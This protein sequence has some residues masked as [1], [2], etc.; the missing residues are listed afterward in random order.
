[1]K[2]TKTTIATIALILV[3]TITA[4][5]ASIPVISAHDPPWT[6]STYSFLSVTPN[7]VGVGQTAYV[8]LWIDKVPPGAIG[9][10]WGYRWHNMTVTVTKPDGE[11]E[12]MGP[13]DSDAVG[14][15]WTAYV[16][17]QIGTYT[18]QSSFPEQVAV[19]EN[20]YPHGAGFI[21]LGYDF[22]NDTYT[23]S[24]SKV[25]TLT[26]QEDP[27]ETAFS[28]NPFPTEYWERPMHSMNRNWYSLGGN[29]LGLAATSFGATGM[30][31]V[32]GNFNPY[33]TAP[34]SAHVVW[35]KPIAFGGQVG[36]ELGPYETSLYATGTAYEAKFGAVIMYGIL[37]YTEYPGAGNNPGDLKAVDLRTGEELWSI[38]AKNPLKCGMIYNFISGD[39]YGAHAYLFTAPASLGFT[40][41]LY[42]PQV[43]SMYD[44]M[45]GD[46]ILDIANASAG[47]LT[48]GPNGELLSYTTSGGMLTMWNASKCIEQGSKLNNIF[49]IYSAYEIWRPPENV[50]IDWSPGNEWSVPVADPRLSVSTVSDDVVLLVVQSGG[51]IG[52]VPGG[53]QVGWRLDAGYS[54]ST[55]ELLWGPINRTLTPWTSVCLGGMQGGTAGEGVYVEYTNQF[56][57]WVG[58]SL[59]TGEKLWGPTEP[60]N[61]TWGYYD[62]TAPAVIGYGNLY[63]WGLGG[64]VYCYDVHTGAEKW[65]WTPGSAGFDTPYGVWALGTWNTHHILADGKLYVRAGHDYTPPVFKGAKLYCLDAY[66]G[67]EIWSSL[68]F[69]ILGSPA[70]ADGYMVWFNGYDN[71]IYCYGMGLTATTVTAPDTGIPLGSSVMIRGTVTDQSPGQ[72]CLGIPAAGTPAISDEYMSEWMEYLY[73]QQPMPADATGVKVTLDAIDPNGNFISI[74]TATSDMSGFYSYMWE[75][76]HEG[77]YTIIATFEGSESYWS[78]YAETAI[79]VTEA[80]SP[81]A[82]IE[83]EPT[84]PEPTEP[85]PTE[86]EPTEPEPT[87]PEPTEP[88]EAPLITTEIAIIIAAVAIAVVIGIVSF[89][90]LRKRK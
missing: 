50:T 9:R 35:T 12:T 73:Q 17:D 4:L 21:P 58:Y 87:E 25:V 31:A 62:W 39:Q 56:M 52:G 34:N 68:S 76:E 84:E 48:T 41:R 63:S 26:V 23:G 40:L 66:T 28:D 79:G 83:P 7:P 45:T 37:Y 80:P 85:E 65:Y 53:A 82:P 30:Y 74:G 22:I 5:I 33:T 27:I 55:G 18:F 42:T 44:A 14:G 15:A 86:P 90:T 64:E 78:S 2:K 61:S 36:G 16:P 49:T 10:G 24:T 38:Y 69:D 89:W 70:C 59:T 13:F 72:T 71:Q 8:G 46:W 43:W 81:A 57:T 3:L 67:D 20:P 6:I 88:T 60:K 54:A 11:I 1:L 29:W 77:K 75:P 19:E 47:T 32:T 51:A